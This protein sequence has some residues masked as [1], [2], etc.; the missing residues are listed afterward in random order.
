MEKLNSTKYNLNI[1]KNPQVII[2]DE[3]NITL[4][5]QNE[6][7]VDSEFL[8][9]LIEEIKNLHPKFKKMLK[10]KDMKFF[11]GY[12]FSDFFIEQRINDNYG[13]AIDFDKESRGIMTDDVNRIILLY[14]N[15]RIENIG[16]ILY[17]ELGHFI[18]AYD[19]FGDIDSVYDLTYSSREELIKA[20]KNDF[21]KH[22]SL[23]KNDDNPYL[24]H[25]VQ[26]NTPE[27]FR[28]TSISETF[29]E[30]FRLTF[31]KINNTKT[32]ELYFPESSVIVKKMVDSIIN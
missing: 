17:H 7:I 11:V 10:D 2:S 18:D 15:L 28:Q 29:A 32:V 5:I 31:N 20:Y 21:I 9:T 8:N 3:N 22:Y 25:F 13:Y 26:D 14:K 16:A 4:E 27:K 12:K 6:L 24:R 30:L 23:I 1:F 19:K